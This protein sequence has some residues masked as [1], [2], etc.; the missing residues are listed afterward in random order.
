M[1][2]IWDI[3]RS[4]W[5]W[6]GLPVMEAIPSALDYTISTVVLTEIADA[7]AYSSMSAL[8]TSVS[9]LAVSLGLGLSKYVDARFDVTNQ[10]IMTDSIHV[11]DH[12]MIIFLVAYAMQLSSL[13]WLF[14]LPKYAS[15][16]HEVKLRSG[17]STL[18]GVRLIALLSLSLLLMVAVHVLSVYEPTACLEFSGGQGC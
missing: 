7:G 18:G 6:I 14:A 9:F 4:Q 11:R 16:A 2:T 8:V 13:L 15:E 10:D 3:V 1:F 17:I 5:F 12:V